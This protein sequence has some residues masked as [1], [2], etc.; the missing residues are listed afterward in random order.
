MRQAA[1]IVLRTSSLLLCLLPA[2]TMAEG[3]DL[4]AREGAGPLTITV[5]ARR[6]EEQQQNVPVSV[7][8]VPGQALQDRG[9]TTA[10]QLQEVVPG[11]FVSQANPRLTSFTLRGLGS[12][13]F[14]EGLESSVAL[15]LDGVYLGR[16]GM[17]IGDLID[18]ERIEV[19]RGPQGTLFGKNATAGTISIFTRKPQFTPETIADVSAGDLGTRQYRGSVTGPLSDTW[20]GRITAYRSERDGL[21]RNRFDGQDLNNIDRQGVRGQLLWAPDSAF[22]TRFIGEIGEVDER[23]CAFP[24]IGKP[25]PAIAASDA[26]MLYQRV[27]GNPADRIADTDVTPRSQVTQQALSAESIWDLSARHRWV[28]LL[29]YRNY[30]FTPKTDDNTAM[31]LVRGGNSAMH[32]QFSEELRLESRW[33]TLD[34][35]AGVFLLDQVTQGR[36]D[37]ILGRDIS[38]WIFGGQIRQRVPT[39]N[40]N[41]TSILLHALLPPETLDGMRAIT[42]FRQHTTS[43]AGFGNLNWHATEQ[44]DLTAGLRY[45][46]EW[47]DTQVTRSRSGGNPSAS[48]LS[49]TNNLSPLGNL[50]GQDLSGVTFDQ[51]LNDTLGGPFQRD[52]AL[53]EGALS[54][55]AGAS[56]R[57]SPEVMTYLTASRGVKSGGVNLGVTGERVRPV[58]RPEVADSLELGVKTLLF[59]ERLLFNLAAYHA[60]V[61]DYQALTFDESGTFLANPRLNNLINVGQVSLSGAE[62]DLQ[63]ALPWQLQLRG[64]LSWNRAITDDFTNA[65]DEDSR[66]NTQDLSGKPLV[67]APRWQGNLALR[68][69]WP[70]W[71]GVAGYAVADYWFRSRFNATVERSR[72]TEIEGYGVAGARLGLRDARGSWD[73]S[74]FVRN[75]NNAAYVNGVTALYGVGDYGVTISEPRVLGG[76]LRLQWR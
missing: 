21:V 7:V 29:A 12:N 40:R 11:L 2:L 33:R 37:A 55:Q 59:E 65:P 66:S 57:W 60:R 30:A 9:I 58:F 76:T 31:D 3:V 63:A 15:F 38:D 20:A 43:L 10:Q 67:N 68:K 32:Q 18:I 53:Q 74:L 70:L 28:N 69:D 42:P 6:I 4:R 49:L 39:A 47:K 56:W 44:L 8:S 62:L 73:L 5:T 24:L 45:T 41:N 54:G 25:T 22:S 19:A 13:A 26:Y 72:K 75:L 71:H 16:P 64:G 23:C 35:V 34:S 36:E 50:I 51:F 52:L 17:S 46:F 61:K 48:P 27:S 14:N 1:F